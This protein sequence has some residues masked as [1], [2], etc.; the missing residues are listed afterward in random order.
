MI[1]NGED[2][3]PFKSD[4]DELRNRVNNEIR[5]VGAEN[6]RRGFLI[7]KGVEVVTINLRKRKVDLPKSIDIEHRP[8]QG[9]E[10]QREIIRYDLE[11]NELLL[12]KKTI[13][14]DLSHRYAA[15]VII[16]LPENKQKEK[17]MGTL[18][19]EEWIKYGLKV[20]DRLQEAMPKSQ[21]KKS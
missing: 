4:F 16:R 17:N 12:I 3:S 6:S 15:K 10:T 1:E 20:V 13:K 7:K 2:H 21:E 19:N 18:G 11:T 14:E 5:L 9:D 8:D